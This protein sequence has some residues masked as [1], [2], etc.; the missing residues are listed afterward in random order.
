[1]RQVHN[2]ILAVVISFI[3]GLI[4]WGLHELKCYEDVYKKKSLYEYEEENE[5]RYKII[6]IKGILDCNTLVDSY[7]YSLID[8]EQRWMN[9]TFNPVSIIKK[10]DIVWLNKVNSNCSKAGYN[11][12]NV[13]FYGFML[14]KLRFVGGLKPDYDFVVTKVLQQDVID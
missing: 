7:R 13:V 1:M 3:I 5:N 14:H 10:D 11:K 6:K 4:S 9:I 8:T 2:R 12:T